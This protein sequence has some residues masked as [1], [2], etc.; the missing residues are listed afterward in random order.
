MDHKP[1]ERIVSIDIL[2][3]FA[4]FGIFLVNMISFHSPILYINP[5]QWWEG[6]LDQITY[7][8][9]DVLAQASFYP[10]FSLLFGYSFVWLREKANHQGLSFSNLAFRRLIFLLGVGLIHAFFIWH[11]DILFQ[12]AILGII[13]LFF[14][15]L[16][17]RTL[18]SSGLFLYGIPTIG[19]NLL[20]WVAPPNGLEIYDQQKADLSVAI[21]QK[22]TFSEITNQR[23]SDWLL[24]NSFENIPFMVISIFSLFLIG[25]G[26]AKL[27]WLERP[28]LH[29]KATYVI[30]ITSVVGLFVKLSPYLFQNDSQTQYL[31]DSIGGLTLAVAYALIIINFSKN[32]WMQPFAFVGRMS[33]SNY[34][35]QSILSTTFFYQ[36]GLGLYGEISLLTGT[37]LATIIFIIQIIFS[38]Y[39]LHRFRYGPVEWLWR[40]VTY[41]KV[42]NNHV[43]RNKST[44]T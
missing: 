33:I 21:Y 6:R 20:L 44:V 37:I 17:G 18:L 23:I 26:I 3:G 31:Q 11:G 38:Q 24:T 32:K 27:K 8:L 40:C 19:L 7:I 9:I 29:Q 28:E 25:A 13:L 15:H 10:L 34:L 30:V 36:Y 16:S 39:W 43:K 42:I 5:L 12:Y 4:I 35:L 2:R 14:L 22:G 1:E 41:L